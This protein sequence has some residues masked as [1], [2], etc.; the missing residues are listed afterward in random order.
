MRAVEGRRRFLVQTGM[1]D[2][3]DNANNRSPGTDIDRRLHS[4]PLSDRVFVGP[5]PARHCLVDDSYWHG[6]LAILF[7]EGSPPRQWD[8]DSAKEIR[9]HNPIIH[10]SLRFVRRL[11]SFNKK[12]PGKF[13][14][15]ERE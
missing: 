11:S 14:A 9:G 5:V 2:V 8:A 1:F 7:S 15:A 3:A 12:C 10:S 4:K 13:V 6:L